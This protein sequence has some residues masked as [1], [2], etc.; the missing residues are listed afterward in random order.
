LK[1][2]KIN[3]IGETFTFNRT[4]NQTDNHNNSHTNLEI[5]PDILKEKFSPILTTVKWS[6]KYIRAFNTRLFNRQWKYFFSSIWK[7][8]GV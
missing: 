4:T 5:Q 3:N 8:Y 1:K 2:K 7:V 6:H